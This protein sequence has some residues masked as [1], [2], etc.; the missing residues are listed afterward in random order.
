[1]GT[2][3]NNVPGAELARNSFLLPFLDVPD[4]L[5]RCG[6]CASTER[7]GI[8]EVCGVQVSGLNRFRNIAVNENGSLV[9][10]QQKKNSE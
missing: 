3:G 1:M 8:W 7:R 4:D 6:L 10:T 5:W 9:I 2:M